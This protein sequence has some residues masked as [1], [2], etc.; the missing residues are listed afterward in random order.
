MSPGLTTERIYAVLKTQIM[1]GELRAGERLDP[2]KLA[3]ELN[4]SATPVRDALH[5]LLGELMVE[6]WPSQG[7]RVPVLSEGALRDLYAWN[8]DLLGVLLRGWIPTKTSPVPV[9]NEAEDRADVVAMLFGA[10]AATLGTREHHR[11][12][13][14]ASER[15]HRARK[16]EAEVLTDLDVEY[17]ALIEAWTTGRAADLRI[18]IARYH[19]RRIRTVPRI[20]ARVTAHNKP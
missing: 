19:R 9:P 13:R 18:A 10:I 8:A 16:A 15:L 11:A 2:A 3:S 20:V 4:A 14:Q 6:A 12:V 5:Q 1:L 7:F 17:A